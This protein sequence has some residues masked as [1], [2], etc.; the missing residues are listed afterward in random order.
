VITG[1]RP[2]T[3]IWLL[4][5]ALIGVLVIGCGA[6]PDARSGGST[7]VSAGGDVPRTILQCPQGS[8]G[9]ET[10][11]YGGTL[12]ILHEYSPTNLGAWWEPHRFVDVQ[13]ARFAVENLVGLDA[14]GRPVPQLATSWEVDDEARTI[15]LHLR[16]GVKFHDGTAFD[17]EAVK[18]NLEMQSSGVKTELKAVASIE[19]IDRHTVRV[20]LSRDDPLF[21]Q[22]LSS[23]MTGRI[24][25]PAA[26]DLYGPDGVRVHPV[27]TGP[28]KFLRFVRDELLE[29]ER[30]EDYWQE[31]LPYLDGVIVKFVPDA[32]TRKLAFLAG[33]GHVLYGVLPSDVPLLEDKG[34]KIAYRTTTLFTL[35]GDSSDPESPTADIR[36]RRA[37]TYALDV[38][39][40]VNGIYESTSTPTNQLAAA[41]GPGWNPGIE[42][43]PYD[44]VKAAELLAEVGITPATPWST[45]LFYQVSE[46]R[47][48]L[49]TVVQE[50]LAR[51]GIKVDLVPL[52]S[53]AMAAK[54]DRGWQGLAAFSMSYNVGT[55]YSS[56]LQ[57][58]LSEDAYSGG[59]YLFIPEDWNATYG[60]MLTESDMAKRSAAYQELNKMAIDDYCLLT[61]MYVM[62][63]IIA[64]APELHDSGFC[65]YCT[66]EFLPETAWLGVESGLATTSNR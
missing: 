20:K 54:I 64:M 29:Y 4:V 14:E 44:P 35:A 8:G 42:G 65:V 37:I 30:F 57:R 58:Y 6:Q 49:Y 53:Q 27:G 13:L 34:A 56:M 31:G 50:Y 25:S 5:S 7:T 26:Y 55:A 61:P 15:T 16:E 28:F 39:A 47:N 22:R 46:D 2:G 19:V 3:L 66:I 59:P 1:V 45:D 11:Q 21:V 51:V 33:E 62:N 10:P 32:F 36:V 23:S 52:D 40:I 12:V 43:Y 48:A 18:W 38:P 60:E 63:G 9:Q 24:T 41:D 17:A